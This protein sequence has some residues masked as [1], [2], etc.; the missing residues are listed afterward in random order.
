MLDVASA[1]RK[2]A[3]ECPALR[4]REAT[5]MLTRVYDATLRPLGLQSSQLSV[6]VAVAMFGEPGA[7]LGALAQKLLMDRTTMTRNVQP[8][9]RAGLVRVSRSP[10][11]ARTRVV[12]LTRAGER[13][14]E[15]AYPLW[16]EAQ[17]R[18]RDFIGAA[19]LDALRAQL[20]ELIDFA[21]RIHSG[22]GL[23]TRSS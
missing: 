20:S 9:E 11:D 13:M 14:I 2:I 8:L 6:L 15:E 23:A 21:P 3:Q 1:A 16:E 4:I 22:G 5:R 18:V 19:R 12:T 10:E 17:R 7:T